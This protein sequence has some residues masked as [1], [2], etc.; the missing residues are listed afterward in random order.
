MVLHPCSISVTKTEKPGEQP[1]G[2]LKT[3][4]ILWND[5]VHPEKFL[6]TLKVPVQ[7]VKFL[8]TWKFQETLES[9]QTHWKV[10]KK[11]FNAP[12]TLGSFQTL[13]KFFS[14]LWKVSRQYE[15]IS[16]TLDSFQILWIPK[17]GT[18]RLRKKHFILLMWL[19]E[20]NNKILL[21]DNFW[22]ILFN[23]GF[24]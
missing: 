9:F 24:V 16:D 7:Y 12:D 1:S 10:Y 8:D 5:F 22:I 15:K 6:D 4:W 3:I 19:V 17:F 2:G 18:S 20:E 23:V 11:F 14:T 21:D 13:W